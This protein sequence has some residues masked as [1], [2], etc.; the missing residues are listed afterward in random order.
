[1]EDEARITSLAAEL[2]PGEYLRYRTSCARNAGF[3]YGAAQVLRHSSLMAYTHGLL[4]GNYRYLTARHFQ[5]Q[6]FIFNK[7]LLLRSM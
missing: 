1:L 3:C 6:A 5:K 7:I 2:G 4:V